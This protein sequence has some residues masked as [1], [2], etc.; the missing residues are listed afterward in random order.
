MASRFSRDRSPPHRYGGDRR[1]PPG[2]RGLDD[3][4]STPLGRE[5]PRGPK[6][7]VESPR[8]HFGGPPGLRGR[9][10]GGRGD[11]RDRDPRDLRDSGPPP[12]RRD[13][14]RDWP[15]PRRDRAFDPRD[16]R[17]VP[18]G[19]GRSRSPP[20]LRDFRDSREPPPRD[21]DVPPRGRRN[22]RDG[23]L[24]PHASSM[25]EPLS[26]P[27]PFRGSHIRGRGRGDRDRGRGRGAPPVDDRDLF[28]RRSRSRD[29][30]R[31][32]DRDRDRL[33]RERDRD[34]D[35]DRDRERERDRDREWDRER[36]RE[37]EIER[38]DRFLDRWDDDRRS[39]RDDRDQR[40]SDRFEPPRKDHQR[41][42][43]KT[44]AVQQQ[45]PPSSMPPQVGTG[46]LAPP[47]SAPRVDAKVAARD[48]SQDFTRKPPTH[49]A[50]QSARDH[51]RPPERHEPPHSVP[52]KP[53]DRSAPPLS[54]LTA[55]PE[56]P[57]FG[58]ISRP[59]P[60]I[61][62]GSS[63]DKRPA[64][65]TIDLGP[66]KP[67]TAPK[68]D[69][70][71][72]EAQQLHSSDFRPPRGPELASKNEL[73]TRP[74]RPPPPV[75]SSSPPDPSQLDHRDS[76]TSAAAGP[77]L[78]PK[79]PD[80]SA[81]KKAFVSQTPTGPR[82]HSSGSTTATP[83]SLARRHS[84]SA[85]GGSPPHPSNR[86]PP[87]S[88]RMS[89]ASGVP[90]APRAF[91]QRP[92][93]PR[94]PAKGSNQW[95]RPGF[96]HGPPAA[97]P[98]PPPP[99]PAPAAASAAQAAATSVNSL[100][101]G[102]RGSAEERDT[103][104]ADKVK[105]PS[106]KLD[107]F[108]EKEKCKAVPDIITKEEESPKTMTQDT[109]DR[110]LQERLPDVYK[111][112][113]E[114]TRVL[115]QQQPEEEEENEKEEADLS[116][117]LRDSGGEETDEED[118]LDEEDFKLGEERF[119]KEMQALAAE[120][121]PPPLQDPVIVDLLLKIQMLG[122][123]ADGAVPASLDQPAAAMEIEEPHQAP[124][125]IPLPGKNANEIELPDE[126]S[127]RD[128][129]KQLPETK[130]K[131]DGLTVENL[132]FLHSGPPTPFSE[133]EELK[134]TVK[135]H[136][137]IKD[138][139][140][141]ELI[142]ERKEIFKE[143]ERLREEYARYYRPWRL[144]VM[145]MDRKKEEA[146]RSDKGPST[147]PPS[148]TASVIP[149]GRRGYRLNSELDF[150]NALKASE[151]SAQEEFERRRDKEASAKPDLTK[152]AV[153]PDMLDPIAKKAA[154]YQDTNQTVDPADAFRV[155]A[156][157]PP[158]NDF[159]PTEHKIFIDAFMQY[160]KK[161]GKIAEC[162][163]GR[164]FQHCVNHYYLTKEEIKY[165]AKLNK[166]WTRRGRG[167]RKPAKTNALMA[168]LDATRPVQDGSAAD[169]GES[170]TPAVT[171]TGRPR[172][173]AAPTF[174]SG[175]G[176]SSNADT[177]SGGATTPAGKR[178]AKDP[179]GEGGSE[180]GTTTGRRGG[181][182]GG[183]G[184]RRAKAAAAAAAAAAASQQQQSPSITTANTPIAAAP[185]KSE[186]E[187]VAV[188]AAAATASSTKEKEE[189]EGVGATPRSRG[190][191]GR[192]KEPPQ[193]APPAQQALPNSG[194]ESAAPTASEGLGGRES[195]AETVGVYGS[196]QP[197]SYW[198]VQEK[199]DFP[200]LVSHF[201]KDFEAIAHF[202]KTK[203]ATMVKNYF[204]REIDAGR[205]D[206]DELALI[207]E[208]KKLRGEPTGPLPTPNVMPKRRYEATPSTIVV[209][210]RP[211]APNSEVPVEHLENRSLAPRVSK[212]AAGPAPLAPPPAPP[213]LQAR[214]PI[215]KERL[216]PRYHPLAQAAA[217]QTPS[218]LS[219]TEEPPPPA[220]AAAAAA[221]AAVAAAPAPQPLAAQR[222]P[223]LGYFSDDRRDI[224][225]VHTLQEP[226]PRAPPSS[227][228]GIPVQ[229]TLS[230]MAV[231]SAAD[232]S[233]RSIV[234]RPPEE[235]LHY[236][237]LAQPANSLAQPPFL[238]PQPSVGP[239]TA[240][241]ATHSRR[242]SRN[243]SSP[244]QSLKPEPDQGLPGTD[245]LVKQRPTYLAPSGSQIGEMGSSSSRLAPTPTTLPPPQPREV[246]RPSSTPA[247]A[248]AEPPRQVPAKRSNIMSIL[249]DE[250]EEPQRKRFA[251]DQTA[252]GGGG[253]PS[254]SASRPVYSP[255]TDRQ[256]AAFAQQQQ[257]QQSRPQYVPASHLQQAQQPQQPQQPPQIAETARSY[258]TEQH[259]TFVPS[260]SAGPA[261][262]DWGARF[263]PR[264]QQQH[265]SQQ[266]V[267]TDHQ[268]PRLSAQ[269][270][271]HPYGSPASRPLPLQ[272]VVSQQQQ[273]Q[274]QQQQTERQQ[275]QHSTLQQ[276]RS[277]QSHQPRS[278]ISSL[279][280][281]S[282][283]AQHMQPYRPGMVSPVQRHHGLS[284]GMSPPQQA[285]S[286]P[287][288]TPRHSVQHASQDNYADGG[289]RN[290]S[291]YQ[292]AL[293]QHQQH[294]RFR[295]PF[296]W[297]APSS[298]RHPQMPPTQSEQQ[299]KQSSLAGLTT[300]QQHHHPSRTPPHPAPL[301]FGR[302]TPPA[303]HVQPISS[304][305]TN[306]QGSVSNVP[307]SL[308]QHQHQLPRSYTPQPQP[309]PQAQT[310]APLQPP[311]L[312][313]HSHSL[314][315][316]HQP[317]P[318][319]A[320]QQ[321]QKQPQQQQGLAPGHPVHIQPRNPGGPPGLGRYGHESGR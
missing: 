132:P 91:H 151:I 128:E 212:P 94:G 221:A 184:G 233:R 155:F 269:P 314:S 290:L 202:M 297:D 159:T 11:F 137:R 163:P 261:S 304:A 275:F 71:R 24:G 39:D 177:E 251:S 207:A 90:T 180:R 82:P 145:E 230:G 42:E 79:T 296:P 240:P 157:H 98:P 166:K 54:S 142:K 16:S 44:S 126:Q 153:I 271:T 34:R 223:R 215:E 55:A 305:R 58:S 118:D 113:D 259:H 321:Q 189:L 112:Q 213:V 174:G 19:R 60:S 87:T 74:H 160:P 141:Q 136:E 201:G 256:T 195:T 158:P 252:P 130:T 146:S 56:V 115:E 218:L 318:H 248:V 181:R 85:R 237:P 9:G 311:P 264:S 268:L 220:A 228:I 66:A 172:R 320:Q 5:P 35:R 272:P 224:R 242:P 161:W 117:L 43:A 173:A 190:G 134:E 301:S 232:S 156:F 108:D 20:P 253:G 286:S 8:S 17:G 295:N 46:S 188:A 76:S 139:L 310:P 114:L 200:D 86:L 294:G 6:A 273:Q 206:L 53:S 238:H 80:D 231:S 63:T 255:S 283:I 199:R 27:P 23:P 103:A 38:R 293:Y 135:T 41:A 285:S 122:M 179:A 274:Q 109:K 50:A 267:S 183:R 72:L 239:A 175:G 191:R 133:M 193:P 222:G 57:A 170:S 149:E 205:T 178:G 182:G 116:L 36:D 307:P 62:T 169:E 162:L 144:A 1:P 107:R 262:Q 10:F 282:P 48:Q 185:P 167:R 276:S 150:Q 18:F 2:P 214:P 235:P 312:H 226:E 124:T 270:P 70:E 49:P 204:Q 164:T 291:Y 289:S 260:A 121:P 102:R 244:I 67:P 52:E 241:S 210:Q 194:L 263:D 140:L 127:L 211:L 280:R 97:P 316:S 89:L 197:T 143:H 33:D 309:Q 120:M 192:T 278:S 234:S 92:V 64:P 265:S 59:A 75:L 257:Q 100:P 95:V 15:P 225:P 21:L 152:E 154:L 14:D 61:P 129:G 84:I 4:N 306:P 104:A 77:P 31:S 258:T 250:P 266:S 198:S 254:Y 110:D 88:P 236:Q 208:A 203:T 101:V 29:P 245:M 247:Q 12:F 65:P 25:L 281:E 299:S 13:S 171:D 26:G 69:R 187:T 28:R 106:D 217:S 30:W 302:N 243:L 277:A 292:E 119:E 83:Q 125:I 315:L 209:G 287:V 279:K 246:S 165:K 303:T 298:Q 168:D 22:S 123:I 81:Q 308:G 219:A 148:S 99:A 105:R 96:G 3:A 111:K 313:Q 78:R 317:P 32:R 73:P 288:Q 51:R 227:M 216:P 45:S 7:L 186:L 37:R 147:P 40:G 47:L 284:Y 131:A 68:A 319:H 196:L 138:A 249:N 176:E 93:A 229:S 300:Q